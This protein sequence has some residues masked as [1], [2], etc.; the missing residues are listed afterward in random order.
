MHPYL[1]PSPGKIFL[2]ARKTYAALVLFARSFWAL[3]LNFSFFLQAVLPGFVP[4]T[5]SG[6]VRARSFCRILTLM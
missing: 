2:P 1:L 4:E 5:G 3:N 6:T